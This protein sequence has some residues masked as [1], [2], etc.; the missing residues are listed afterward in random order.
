MMVVEDGKEGSVVSCLTQKCKVICLLASSAAEDMFARLFS[1]MLKIKE[2]EVMYNKRA[3]VEKLRE[4][5]GQRNA[6]DVINELQQRNV[7]CT[8]FERHKAQL[9]TFCRQIRTSG[10]QIEGKCVQKHTPCYLLCM[11]ACHISFQITYSPI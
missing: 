7:E 4:A 1:G 3:Q 2:V 6:D 11:H 8:A 5:D 9:G 10:L